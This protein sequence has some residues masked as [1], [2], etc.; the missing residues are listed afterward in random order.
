MPKIVYFGA[1]PAHVAGLPTFAPGESREVNAA[2]AERLL[3]NV[4]F[5]PVETDPDPVP[6]AAGAKPAKSKARPAPEGHE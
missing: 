3:K 4:H 6:E 1:V 2:T 5:G